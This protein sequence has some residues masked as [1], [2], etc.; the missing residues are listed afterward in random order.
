MKHTDEASPVE[1]DVIRM[2][3][4]CDHEIWAG[5]F[6]VDPNGT[7]PECGCEITIDVEPDCIEYEDGKMARPSYSVE[8]PKC[9][10]LLEWPQEWEIVAV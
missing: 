8:C 3:T 9:K 1:G 7:Q 6:G 2:R 4:T 10:A 5:F